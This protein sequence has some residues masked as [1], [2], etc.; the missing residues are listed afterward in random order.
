MD[1]VGLDGRAADLGGHLSD[2]SGYM[3]LDA[4]EGG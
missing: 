1:W 3:A 4:K 2:R